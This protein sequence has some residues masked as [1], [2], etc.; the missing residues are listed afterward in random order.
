MTHSLLPAPLV[1]ACLVAAPALAAPRCS[2]DAIH[3]LLGSKGARMT[4]RVSDNAQA[5][6]TRLWVQSGVI[7]FTR[8][9]QAKAPEHGDL[10]LDDPT[11]FIYR[12][13]QGYRGPDSFDL[14]AFGKDRGGSAVTGRLHVAV[15]V[16][17]HR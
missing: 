8:L 14:L 17:R 11:R 10:M 1:L 7:P 5:C 2:M 15:S 6:G 3:G 12:P 9:E 16:S 13:E 4:M